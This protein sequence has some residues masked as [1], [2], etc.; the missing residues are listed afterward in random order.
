M[1]RNVNTKERKRSVDHIII[2]GQIPVSIL[3]DYIG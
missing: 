2:A 3:I 1:N